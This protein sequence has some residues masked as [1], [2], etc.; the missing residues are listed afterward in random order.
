LD[1]SIARVGTEIAERLRPCEAAL[2]RLDGIPGV[3][4]RTAEVLLA[5]ISA[6]MARFPTAGP[7]ASWAGLCPGKHRGTGKRTSGKTRNGNCWLKAALTEAAQ[8][9]ARTVKIRGLLVHVTFLEEQAAELAERIAAL[10][11]QAPMVA[12]LTTI[13]GMGPTVAAIPT[14]IRDIRRFADPKKLVAFAGRNPS[15]HQ[16]GQFHCERSGERPTPPANT[17]PID[18]QSTP[19]WSV[20]ARA[21]V[22][23]VTMTAITT[24][25]SMAVGATEPDPSR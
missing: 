1:E 9:A 5:E 10:F 19:A 14:E 13:K 11:A 7:L 8:A 24:K 12:C 3:G 16:S 17:I 25:R 2:E 20:R 6:G 21:I 23:S 22:W 4:R 15:W 18:R